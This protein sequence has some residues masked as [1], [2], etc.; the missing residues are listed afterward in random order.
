MPACG[1]SLFPVTSTVAGLGVDCATVTSVKL[2]VSPASTNQDL[3]E[4]PYPDLDNAALL[5]PVGRLQGNRV[6]GL[7]AGK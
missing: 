4:L 2:P 3:H 7:D 1:R 6:A 5:E